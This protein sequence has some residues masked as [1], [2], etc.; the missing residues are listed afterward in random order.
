MGGTI[1]IGCHTPRLN[2]PYGTGSR[3]FKTE[4][5][6]KKLKVAHVYTC[7]KT[8]FAPALNHTLPQ[9][10]ASFRTAIRIV[11]TLS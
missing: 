5:W 3:H 8:V 6:F 11:S 2:G 10:P 9:G 7:H 1:W 4:I